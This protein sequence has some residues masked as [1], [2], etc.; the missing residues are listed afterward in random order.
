[1]NLQI[2]DPEVRRKAEKLA[3]LRNTTLTRAVSDALDASLKLEQRDRRPLFEVAKKLNA[4]MRALSRG[5]GHVMTKEE[6]DDMWGQ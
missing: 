4:E 2:R 6:I 5:A 3:R 1:M